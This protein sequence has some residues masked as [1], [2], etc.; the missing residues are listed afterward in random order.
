MAADKWT[1]F[2]VGRN[3]AFTD[4]RG[5]Q[6]Q[7]VHY[8]MGN[9]GPTKRGPTVTPSSHLW[10]WLSRPHVPL[11]ES[12]GVGG[13]GNFGPNKSSSPLSL[14]S[15][16]SLLINAHVENRCW[17]LDPNLVLRCPFMECN[18]CLL[19][20]PTPPKLKIKQIKKRKRKRKKKKN[21]THVNEIII[22][23]LFVCCY[24]WHD[25][26]VMV[27][28]CEIWCHHFQWNVIFC[29]MEPW[30]VPMF[31]FLVVVH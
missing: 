26:N 13:P 27:W 11:P 1:F 2:K 7:C 6:R 18:I 10:S 9:V 12:P 29:E 8:V 23:Y 25:N 22:T 3:D 21:P 28:S 20:D 4:V 14:L 31:F 30:N 5:R 17:N 19:F 16:L 15:F 24:T